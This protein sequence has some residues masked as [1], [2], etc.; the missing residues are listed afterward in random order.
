MADLGLAKWVSLESILFDAGTDLRQV[1]GCRGAF[2]CGCRPRLRGHSAK[3]HLVDG[4][5]MPTVEIF[6]I[7]WHLVVNHGFGK[8]GV[9]HVKLATF[10]PAVIA[11]NYNYIV[12]YYNSGYNE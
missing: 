8:G 3:W 6:R 4:C 2:A 1:D 11:K 5:G 12:D 10:P 7:C 9:G